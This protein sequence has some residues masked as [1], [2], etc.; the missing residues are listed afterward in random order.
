M[1]LLLI[2]HAD[3]DYAHD[4][5]T[6][7]GHAEARLLAEYL[8][9][10]PLDAIYVSPMGRAQLTAGYTLERLGREATTLDWLAELDGNYR[11][12]LWSWGL[13]P[14]EALA[15]PE[16]YGVRSWPREVVYGDHMGEVAR[17]FY[18]QFDALMREHGYAREGYRYRVLRDN[19]ATV[20]LFCHG[21]VILTLLAHLIQMAVPVAY[22]QFWVDPASI[23]AL[24]LEERDGYAAFRLL[25]FNDI[26]HL[27]PIRGPIHGQPYPRE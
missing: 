23:T 4:A 13:P 2:R 6:P 22:A 1:K 17:R 7:K 11:E 8:T 15:R 27:A 24:G 14:T 3:P 25:A 12:R 21:G 9:R 10:V 26:G 18:A 5:L 19:R 16:P 20:A